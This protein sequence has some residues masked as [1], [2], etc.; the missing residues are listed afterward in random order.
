MHVNDVNATINRIESDRKMSSSSH[1]CDSFKTYRDE[2]NPLFPSAFE[3]TLEIRGGPQ[4]MSRQR[5][6]RRLLER[7]VR[8]KW[9]W[10]KQWLCSAVRWGQRSQG[11]WPKRAAIIKIN[12]THI[13]V[14]AS[15]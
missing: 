8:G 1:K 12:W 13:E 2:F 4:I 11:K 5:V 15:A 10:R 3:R 6:D 9:K 7:S 14:K